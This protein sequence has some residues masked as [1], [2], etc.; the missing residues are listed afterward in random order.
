MCSIGFIRDPLGKEAQLPTTLTCS[1]ASSLLVP[2]SSSFYFFHFLICISYDH[3]LNK[4][5]LFITPIHKKDPSRVLEGKKKLQ[6][7]RPDR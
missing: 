1:S 6:K 4:L 5:F 7:E 2:S 3:F